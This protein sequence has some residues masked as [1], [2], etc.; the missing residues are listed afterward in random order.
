MS[1]H[2]FLLV[3]LIY[4][5]IGQLN[6]QSQLVCSSDSKS[7]ILGTTLCNKSK[8]ANVEVRLRE[9][10]GNS[11]LD[12]LQLTFDAIVET[13]TTDNGQFILDVKKSN[14]YDNASRLVL[15]FY[16]KCNL[17]NGFGLRYHA[18]F[19]KRECID[20]NHKL[21]TRCSIGSIQLYG[22]NDT[23]DPV[24]QSTTITSRYKVISYK[25]TT[26]N[27]KKG[28]RNCNIF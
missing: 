26:Q 8:E 7:C 18:R 14:T 2:I 1:K 27:S 19:L 21:K 10:T 22:A 12:A 17:Q 16:H 23:I 20:D 3:F 28:K 25:A 11:L 24:T 9:I 4:F 13:K 5:F 6:V 15:Y